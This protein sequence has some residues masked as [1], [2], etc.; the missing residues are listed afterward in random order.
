MHVTCCQRKVDREGG[1]AAP[2]VRCDHSTSYPTRTHRHGRSKAPGAHAESKVKSPYRTTC[3]TRQSRSHGLGCCSGAAATSIGISQRSGLECRKDRQQCKSALFARYSLRRNFRPA[4][5]GAIRKQHSIKRAVQ[6][7]KLHV[8]RREHSNS[9]V[10]P[11][12]ASGPSTAPSTC[13][14]ALLRVHMIN[15]C[16][17]ASAAAVTTC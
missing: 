10:A 7:K 13:R 17:R 9:H 3:A 11:T 8:R 1:D 6:S 16:P 12:L 5:I 14:V 2:R 4:S 15:H